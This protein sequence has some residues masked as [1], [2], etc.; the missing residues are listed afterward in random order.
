MDLRAFIHK[1]VF[2]FLLAFG[3]GENTF[4]FPHKIDNPLVPYEVKFADITFQ[5]NDVTRYLIQTE[6]KNIQSNRQSVQNQLDKITL[7]LPVVEPILKEQNVPDDFK[8]LVSYNKYQS[9]IETSTSLESGVYWC[10]DKAKAEDVDLLINSQLDERKHLIAATKGAS[11]CLKRNYVLYKNWG[12]T[13][14]SHIS[15][16]KVLSLLEVSRKWSGNAYILLDSPAYSAILQF[17]AYKIAIER[18]FPAYKPSIQKIIYEYPYSKG[19]TLNRISAELKVEPATLNEYNLWLTAKNVPDTECQVLVVV[20]ASRYSEVRTLAELSRKSG[21]PVKD[22]GFPVLKREETVAKKGK[23]INKGGIF[24]N[25]NDLK[26]VQAEMCDVAVTMA[27]KADISIENFV[28]YN[29]MKVTDLLHI[30]Q[31]YYIEKK[32][33]KASVPFHVVR[34]GETLWDISQMYGVRLSNLLDY[35]RLETVQRLQR[36][37]IVWLQTTRPKNKPIEYIEMPDEFAVIEEMLS[38]EKEEPF[39]PVPLKEK[40]ET[41]RPQQSIVKNNNSGPKETDLNSLPLSQEIKKEQTKNLDKNTVKNDVPKEIDRNAARINS[42][43]LSQEIRKEQAKDLNL[44]KSVDSED[45]ALNSEGESKVVLKGEKVK[46][47]DKKPY[48][49]QVASREVNKSESQFVYHTVRRDETLFRISV[50]YNVSVENLWRMNN[51]SS[52]II[53]VG[54]VLKVKRL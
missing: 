42:L 46:K 50:N 39:V 35:N 28:E 30:G 47:E 37:R 2:V 4:A 44:P 1:I 33:T 9:S 43:P 23:G 5:L 11:M 22:L 21:L 26:G 49:E 34:E 36:G 10:L 20:P 3:G 14:F 31:V 48:S 51:L 53:E 7:F 19:K 38:T 54:T 52:T 18:E 12:T 16:K 41:I 27:Y 45:I 29:D 24:F 6:L 25:I 17:L 32:N 8:Y 15:D 13:L 40:I